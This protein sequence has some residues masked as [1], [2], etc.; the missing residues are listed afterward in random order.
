[1]DLISLGYIGIFIAAFAA[2]TLFPAPS[3]LIILVAFENNFNLYLVILVATAGNTLGSL[4]NYYLGYLSNSKK[5]MSSFK[6]NEEK[7]EFWT[8]KTEKYGHWLGLIA[9][10]PIIGDPIIALVGF[11][12]VKIIPLTATITIGKL[13]RYVIVTVIYYQT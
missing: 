10:I 2:S 8:K 6:L 5:L 4:T 12:R 1:M 9:W 3:E 11:L 7:I 13:G